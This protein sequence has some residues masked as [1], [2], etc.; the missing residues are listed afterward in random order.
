MVCGCRLAS[1][2]ACSA[3]QHSLAYTCT[4]CCVY[5]G[6]AVHQ[7]AVPRQL[8]LQPGMRDGICIRL[9]MM[10]LM[11]C[12]RQSGMQRHAL[13][14][15]NGTIKF[16]MCIAGTHAQLPQL[17]VCYCAG[18][19]LSSMCSLIQPCLLLLLCRCHCY[20]LVTKAAIPAL[21]R[22]RLLPALRWL[23]LS[24]ADICHGA[25]PHMAT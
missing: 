5:C 16:D 23:R 4:R 25:P 12:E 19:R 14:R 8:P 2:R 22:C 20:Q 6:M 10:L 13:G 21:L 15:A 17:V 7:H 9:Q 1:A 18:S 11:D 3:C 24:A